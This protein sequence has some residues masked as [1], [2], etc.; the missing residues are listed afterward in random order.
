MCAKISDY[1]KAVKE[2]KKALDK[3]CRAR[4]ESLTD[5]EILDLLVNRK[6]F[7]SIFT[8]I[9][10]LFAAI[11]HRLTNRI[12]ELAERYENTLPELEKDVAEYEAKV[13]SHLE[14]MGFKW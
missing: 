3:K 9:A 6:W 8:G 12:I 7:G 5:K 2:L 4:Y 14:R 1:N 10:D 11:S 13:K